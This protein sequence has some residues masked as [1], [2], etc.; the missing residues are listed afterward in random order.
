M[1]C[2]EHSPNL[3]TLTQL[4]LPALHPTL[5]FKC[6]IPLCSFKSP[7]EWTTSHWLTE[8]M[9]ATSQLG[10]LHSQWSWGPRILRIIISMASAICP[11]HK[12]ISERSV[13]ILCTLSC[14]VLTNRHVSVCLSVSYPWYSSEHRKFPLKSSKSNGLHGIFHSEC[15]CRCNTSY[16]V[17]GVAE[18]LICF[19][20]QFLE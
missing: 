11:H 10:N 19:M 1:P 18:C 7:L 13:Y 20:K 9:K 5:F 14:E 6:S 17:W 16:K 12:N 4:C 15:I 8:V 3:P 2:H